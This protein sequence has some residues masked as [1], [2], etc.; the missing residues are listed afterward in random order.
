MRI[1]IAT[2]NVWALP[3]PFAD[4][5]EPRMRA[6]GNHLGD[7]DLD[8]MAF[9]EVWIPEARQ[10]LCEAGRRCGLDQIWHTEAS[11]GGSGLLVLSRLPIE[12]TRFDRFS[13]RGLPERIDHGEYYGGKGFVRLRLRT[14]RGAITFI[15]THLHARY[16]H[17]IPPAYRA[18]RTGQM[19]EL[20]MAARETSD[21]IV[22]VGDFN[23]REGQPEYRVLT[24]LTGLVDVA[25]DLDQREPTVWSGNAYRSCSRKPDRRIDYVF[26][27]HGREHGV[28]GRRVERC[29]HE[30]LEFEDGPASYSDHAGVL[31][32]LELVP[33][34]APLRTPDPEA[35]DL[36]TAMLSEGRE[37]AERR[38][39]GGRT[40][41]GVGFGCAALASLSVRSPKL[42]RRRVLR[43]AVQAAG[44]MALTPGVAFSLLS[45]VFAPSEIRAFESLEAQLSRVRSQVGEEVLA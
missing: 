34:S 25:A 1:R 15:D 12:A 27:R 38:Q 35:V 19:V 21:P 17:E 26:T 3:E 5:V 42:S 45:E 8:V 23:V 37:D 40:L 13:L 18:F 24:G 6:I 11:L 39:R 43:G 32:E 10:L 4:R 28:L 7:L 41:A 36:A 9:Q 29:F 33:T 31:A 30:P 20:A 44:L 14:E 2:L 22:A 16:R